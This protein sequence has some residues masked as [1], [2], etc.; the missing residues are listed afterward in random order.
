MKLLIVRHGESEADILKVCEGWADFSLTE[1]GN[2]QAL[3]TGK[4][5]V[6][7]YNIDKIYTSTLKRARETAHYLEELTGLSA[8]G[9]D[10]LKE[11]N[12]GLRAG[13]PY[14]EAYQKYPA[15]EVPIHKALYKQESKLE[16]R[17]RVESVL[18]E[19]L[20]QNLS[21]NTIVIVTH[22]ETITQLYHA[23]LKLPIDAKIKFGTG[24][25][26]LHEWTIENKD[27][28]IDRSNYCPYLKK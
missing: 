26:C 27:Y 4:W 10:N 6:D 23:L 5:I 22:G 25:A 28:R 2:K 3:K 16:F 13:L 18:S 17:M 21:D 7:H 9:R 1:R 14:E 12:N 8:I 24:D 11:F 19:I 20:S 15:V